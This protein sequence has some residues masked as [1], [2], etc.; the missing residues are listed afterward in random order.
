MCHLK[1]FAVGNPSNAC[2][3]NILESS[4]QFMGLAAFLRSN[5]TPK[6]TKGFNLCALS[7]YV[8][9]GR[10]DLVEILPPPSMD[11]A[12]HVSRCSLQNGESK[13]HVR[14]KDIVKMV[15]LRRDGGGS[16]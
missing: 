6:Q 8:L 10:P 9:A 16:G 11:L 15:A 12:H 5:C 3:E 1:L 7:K 2:S 13:D 4:L 14:G